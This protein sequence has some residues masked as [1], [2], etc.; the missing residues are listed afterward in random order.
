MLEIQLWSQ[1]WTNLLKYIKI[2][3]LHKTSVCV[4]DTE[5]LGLVGKYSFSGAIESKVHLQIVFYFAVVFMLLSK[6]KTNHNSMHS[7]NQLCK[8]L[9]FLVQIS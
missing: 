2:Y 8:G 7:A 9:F 4:D 5:R 3:H 1:K 6:M